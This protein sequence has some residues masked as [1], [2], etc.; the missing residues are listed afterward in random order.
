MSS[1][2]EIV[3]TSPSDT[4][5]IAG[6][7]GRNL[8][9]GE[10]IDLVG[11]LGSGKTE[12]VRG[13]AKAISKDEASSPSF[14]IENIYRA[15]KFNIHHF[16]F[17]RLDNPGLMKQQL[18]EVISNNQVAAV[19]WGSI[20]EAVLPAERLEIAFRPEDTNKRILKITATGEK[21]QKLIKGLGL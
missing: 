19:E 12:F 2:L 14:T 1:T 9:G 13:L 17:H 15:R 3:S 4:L 20:V 8:K 6:T 10:V 7:L 5:R 21:Y 11:D 18:E 16:D